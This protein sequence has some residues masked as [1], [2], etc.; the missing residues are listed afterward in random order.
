MG[1][2]MLIHKALSPRAFAKRALKHSVLAGSKPYISFI[3]YIIYS[4]ISKTGY[5]EMHA[6]YA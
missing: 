4:G 3:P 2:F 5:A 6:S 1:I